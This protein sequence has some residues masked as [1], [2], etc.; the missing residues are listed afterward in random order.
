MSTARGWPLIFVLCDSL[1]SV[2]PD[3]RSPSVCGSIYALRATASCSAPGAPLS[4]SIHIVFWSEDLLVSCQLINALRKTYF[5]CVWVF[6]M[7]GRIHQSSGMKLLQPH[8]LRYT[9]IL[10]TIIRFSVSAEYSHNR[11]RY[12]GDSSKSCSANTVPEKFS[13]WRCLCCFST[14]KNMLTGCLSPLASVKLVSPNA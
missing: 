6:S 13:S 2:R 8:L 9:D 12:K 5:S 7:G 1:Y 4:S 14:I 11:Y 3:N 10:K